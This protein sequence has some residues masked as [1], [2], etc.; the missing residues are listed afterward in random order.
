[1]TQAFQ[2]DVNERNA[3]LKLLEGDDL[4]E[5]E[6]SVDLKV[7]QSYETALFFFI[8]DIQ[9]SLARVFVYGIFSG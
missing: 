1:M 8:S 3:C 4:G 9:E 2:D 7:L 5:F 6:Y